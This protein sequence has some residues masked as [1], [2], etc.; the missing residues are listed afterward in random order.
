VEGG[1]G[2]A[3][4]TVSGTAP[5]AIIRHRQLDETSKTLSLKLLDTDGGK[6]TVQIAADGHPGTLL[7]PDRPE[8]AL[9]VPALGRPRRR[10]KMFIAL[11]DLGV[12]QLAKEYDAAIRLGSFEIGNWYLLLAT[13]G[14]VSLR[15]GKVL[16]GVPEKAAA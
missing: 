3:S 10:F 12:R 16:D 7:L 15:G 13:S 9:I 6:R 2:R 4:L 14:G 11:P 8:P 1:R 5:A